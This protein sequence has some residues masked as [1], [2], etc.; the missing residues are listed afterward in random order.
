MHHPHMPMPPRILARMWHP[1]TALRERLDLALIWTEAL[2]ANVLGAT[3]GRR[4]WM[5]P[6]QLQAE[7]R[8]T[9]THELIHVEHGHRGCQPD[10]IEKQVRD[11]AARR[12]IP[13]ERLIDACLWARGP[14][15]LADELWVDQPTLEDRL[16]G[17]TQAERDAINAALAQRDTHDV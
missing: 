9:L 16:S 12:L 15:E 6:R 8:C 7:R 4:I 1:W 3:D 11:A 14:E 2:P 5:T 17:L 10:A 13:L